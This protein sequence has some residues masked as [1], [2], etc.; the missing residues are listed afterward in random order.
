[1]PGKMERN[2]LP[3]KVRLHSLKTHAYR[4]W[5]LQRAGTLPLDFL[6]LPDA[7]VELPM[8]KTSK[9][10]LFAQIVNYDEF[11]DALR[12]NGFEMLP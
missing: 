1:M 9:P 6:E 3:L 7:P 2:S 8:R 11:C 4:L 12:R 5:P 10:D